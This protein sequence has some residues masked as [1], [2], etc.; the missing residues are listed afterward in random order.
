MITK[1]VVSSWGTSWYSLPSTVAVTGRPVV[2]TPSNVG[3][4]TGPK[5]HGPNRA[6]AGAG[7]LQYGSM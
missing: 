4:E 3:R 1:S 2:F 5:V 7:G 6:P